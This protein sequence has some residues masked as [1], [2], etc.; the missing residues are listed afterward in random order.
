MELVALKAS[1]LST[2]TKLAPSVILVA[3]VEGWR[4]DRED[5]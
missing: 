4:M 1:I 3:M 5:L 2:F